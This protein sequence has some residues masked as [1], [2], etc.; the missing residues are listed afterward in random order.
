M[1]PLTSEQRSL[2]KS[3][4]LLGV[5]QRVWIDSSRA[6]LPS[7]QDA[8]TAG[9]IK[10]ACNIM[11]LTCQSER[12]SPRRIYSLDVSPD[13]RFLAF[14]HTTERYTCQNVICLEALYSKPLNPASDST[15]KSFSE[16][17]R[18]AH[19]Q[20]DALCMTPFTFILGIPEIQ[21]APRHHMQFAILKIQQRPCRSL[22]QYN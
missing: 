2:Q 18:Y 9:D 3:W 14:A 5:D 19:S 4:D 15:V 11:R 12:C 7:E 6:I 20:S 21:W 16:M 1:L 13:G 17:V 22:R 8:E 10:D